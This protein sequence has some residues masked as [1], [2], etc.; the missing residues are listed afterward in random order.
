[1]TNKALEG[2]L[3][4]VFSNNKKDWVVK[5]V[6]AT[7]ACNTTWKNTIT[8]TPFKFFY[9]KKQLLS[10]EF[11]YKTLRMES[12][13]DIHITRAQEERLQQLNSL[14]ELRLQSLMHIK[15]VQLQRNV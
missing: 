5:I 3:T 11:E 10:I 2:I 4:K 14:D 12:H 15:V 9:G 8:F 6:E 1:V 13:L 7:W